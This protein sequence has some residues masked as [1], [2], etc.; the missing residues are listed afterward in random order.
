MHNNAGLTVE[1]LIELFGLAPLPVEGGLF[2]QTYR[3]G[4]ALAASALPE[5]FRA[6]GGPKPAS[7][8]IVVL[9]TAEADS[10]SALHKLPTDEVYH[11]YLGDPIE[12][13]QLY[14]HGRSERVIL[15]QDVLGGQRVQYV[16]PREVWMGSHL[17]PGGRF[18]LFGTT[19]A[20]GFTASDY[21]GG[22]R[23]ALIRQYPHEA[24]LIRRLTRPEAPL[25][26]PPDP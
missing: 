8:A 16:A 7:T 6:A 4:D 25:G 17:L 3:S 13:L 23:Q 9:F 5:R 12:M 1:A 14:P 21:V 22:D 2:R 19:M 20:P 11:F 24:Q 15:G 10:F 26:M 18:A